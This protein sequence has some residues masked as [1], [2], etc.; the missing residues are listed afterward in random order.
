MADDH[1][2]WTQVCYPV[3]LK[4]KPIDMRVL[5]DAALYRIMGDGSVMRHDGGD[6]GDEQDPRSGMFAVETWAVH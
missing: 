6:P 2:R 5:G 3:R 1:Y 4:V